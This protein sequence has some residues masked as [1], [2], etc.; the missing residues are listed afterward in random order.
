MSITRSHSI[1]IGRSTRCSICG[2]HGDTVWLDGRNVAADICA[3]CVKD[4][5]AY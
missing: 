1:E 3:M 2:K 5:E 4:A